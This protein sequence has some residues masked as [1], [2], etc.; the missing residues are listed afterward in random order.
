M[1]KKE[2]KWL[3]NKQGIRTIVTIKEKPLSEEWLCSSSGTNTD[4]G[5]N[6]KIDYLHI[7][8]NDY[9]FAETAA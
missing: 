4:G 8:V 7:S 3:I 5:S 6:R 1:S 2:A 9:G